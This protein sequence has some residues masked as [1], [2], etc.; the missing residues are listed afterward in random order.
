[1]ARAKYGV[2]TVFLK[3]RRGAMQGRI[4]VRAPDMAA[5]GPKAVKQCI[6]VS[7][8]DTAPADWVVIA[9]MAGRLPGAGQLGRAKAQ[10]S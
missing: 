7:Y 8:P 4:E 2:W 3:R 5:A 6:E 10:A 9:C 1:M